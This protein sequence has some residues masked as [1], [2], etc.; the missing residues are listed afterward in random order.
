MSDIASAYPTTNI[1][2]PVVSHWVAWILP[3]WAWVR[4]LPLEP[5]HKPTILDRRKNH[6]KFTQRQRQTHWAT[7]VSCRCVPMPSKHPRATLTDDLWTDSRHTSF[8]AVERPHRN[9]RQQQ[10]HRHR[11]R[12]Q[13]Q[14]YHRPP[15]P[16]TL[17]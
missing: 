15:Q 6:P 5:P 14:Q 10:Q 9:E 12:Q 2:L 11:H 8:Q 7:R 3:H 4:L 16:R 1:V 13:Q 17:I